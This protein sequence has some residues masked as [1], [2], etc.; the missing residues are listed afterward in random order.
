MV[1]FDLET[2]RRDGNAYTL[3]IGA[4]CDHNVFNIYVN[5]KR[6]IAPTASEKTGLRQIGSDLY[7]KNKKLSSVNIKNALLNFKNYLISLTKK[8]CLSVAHN[9]NF[10]SE[11]FI[12]ALMNVNMVQEFKIIQ[13]FSCT[14]K[15]LR[16]P[17]RKVHTLESLVTDLISAQ[18]ENDSEEFHDAEY[19]VKILKKITEVTKCTDRVI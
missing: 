15:M 5:P 3:Q 19:D 16:L 7:H 11:R 1:L 13:G 10:D 4:V 17:E 14:L 2:T 6:K 8:L 9:A 12:R 18:S